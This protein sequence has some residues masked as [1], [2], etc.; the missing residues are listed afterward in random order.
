MRTDSRTL[1]TIVLLCMLSLAAIAAR[2]Q[3]AVASAPPAQAALVIPGLPGG[4]WSFVSSPALHPAAVDV[5]VREP[6]L[7]PGYVFVAPIASPQVSG[8]FLGQTGP[9]I[10]DDDGNPVWS[11]PLPPGVEATNFRR[12]TYRGAPVLT[13]WEGRIRPD[14]IGA[15]VGVIVD[16]SYRQI[17]VVHGARGMGADLHEF[18]ITRRNTALLSSYVNVAANLSSYGGPRHGGIWD[19]LVEEVDIRTGRVLFR[20]DALKHVRLRESYVEPEGGGWDPFHVNSIDTDSAGNL[21]ISMRN[22]W[23]VYKVARRTG[24]IEWRLGGRRSSFRLAPEARF[25]WQHDAR[26]MSHGRL[27]L[28]DNE[29]EP[30]ERPRSRGVVLKLDRRRRRAR[31]VHQY[32][33]PDVLAV[34]QGSS[35]TL[36]NG[37]AF[38]GWG[39][40]P[41]FAEFSASGRLLFDARFYGSDESYRAYR[42]PWTAHP[43]QGPVIAARPS[44]ASGAPVTVIYASWNG[45]TELA[46]WRVLAGPDPDHL[47]P[48][49]YAP[50]AG[51]ETAIA[52][53][54][55]GPYF[56]AEALDGS[57]RVL[58][59]SAAVEPG[60]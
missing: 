54:S 59:T 18:L 56:A 46:A 43:V 16:A 49:A 30:A 47:A 40:A 29:A 32:T 57:G 22:T 45:A 48:V 35:Q 34:S 20:W 58:R 55:A 39:A 2:A 26:F 17:A 25:A 9:L 37:D 6:G 13:W 14:G 23:A 1:R 3:L 42:S 33:L 12:Q 4:P 44:G 10:L 21:L 24:R 53:A 50:R 31:L 60:G 27:S 51:F 36:P 15:G 5:T 7:A 38:E 52:A 19:Q 41:Y 8:P 28:F 11:H